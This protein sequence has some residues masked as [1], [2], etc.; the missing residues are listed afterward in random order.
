MELP[1]FRCLCLVCCGGYVH[2]IS[3]DLIASLT[4]TVSVRLTNLGPQTV[5]FK[6]F[7]Q[8]FPENSRRG[9]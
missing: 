6:G 1:V 3:V 2:E 8:S 9:L 5:I 4:I 7:R